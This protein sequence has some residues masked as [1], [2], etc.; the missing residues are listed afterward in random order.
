ME[1]LL[2]SKLHTQDR[3]FGYNITS[4][5]DVPI[6]YCDE[7]K[8]KISN[9]VSGEHHP[10]YGK[11]LSEET[12]QRISQSEKGA[13]KP[14]IALHK[15]I[16]IV[17]AETGIVYPSAK[18]AAQRTSIQRTGIVAALKGRRQTAGGYHWNYYN[19]LLIDS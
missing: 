13:K 4:G 12:K 3:E 7:V 6:T 16:P 9:A 8:Q 18:I 11:H 17:C 5:G 19:Q 15:S 10:C 1:E 14:T 2:I